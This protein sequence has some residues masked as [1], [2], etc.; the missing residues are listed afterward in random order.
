MEA[1][2][3]AGAAHVWV[4]ILH[5]RPGTR[6]HYRFTT[7]RAGRVVQSPAGRTRTAPA[8][9][10]AVKVRFAFASCQAYPGRYFNVWQQLADRDGD[11]FGTPSTGQQRAHR[12][13]GGPLPVPVRVDDRAG[14]L[15]PRIRRSAGWR[16]VESLALRDVGPV[17]RGGLDLDQYL[18]GLRHRVGHLGPLENVDTAGLPDHDSAHGAMLLGAI[19]QT[20]RGRASAGG[21]A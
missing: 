4:S 14:A 11:P 18:V 1:A 6:Y 2:C 10:Q 7:T 8:A 21:F 17:D 3:E 19:W 5:L 15:Q 13:A 12:L 9:D 20:G 16:R